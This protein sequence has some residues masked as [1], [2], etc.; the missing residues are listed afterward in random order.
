MDWS[1]GYVSDVNYTHGYYAGLN[2]LNLNLALIHAGIRPPIIKKLQK[3]QRRN[4]LQ[5]KN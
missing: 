4:L 2:P 5:L 3:F 1:S